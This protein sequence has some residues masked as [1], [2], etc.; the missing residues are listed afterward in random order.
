MSVNKGD[1]IE[2]GSSK[3]IKSENNPNKEKWILILCPLENKYHVQEMEFVLYQLEDNNT[4]IYIIHKFKEMLPHQ[5]MKELQ[6][7]KKC[8]FDLLKNELEKNEN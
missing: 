7:K 6:L 5:T 1:K 3:I 8:L 2:S 4:F